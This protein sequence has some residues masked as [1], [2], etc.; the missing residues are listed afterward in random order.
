MSKFQSK[1]PEPD[2]LRGRPFYGAFTCMTCDYVC[3]EAFH[4]QNT[5]KLSW[6]CPDKHLSEIDF[7]I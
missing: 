3:T 1:D 7:K 5:N 2:E 4:N 6:Q